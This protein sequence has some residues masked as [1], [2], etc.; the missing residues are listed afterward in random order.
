MKKNFKIYS[1][2][3]TILLVLF[4]AVV[5]LARPVIPGYE[6]NYDARF[7][8]TLSLIF[9]AFIGNLVCA[10]LA[11]K[12]ENL[13]KLFYN[14]PLLT[15]SRSALIIMTV[16]GS[17]LMLIPDC[18]AWIAAAV[19]IFI[20]AVNSFAVIK[21]RW[22]T[23][24][25]DQVDEKVKTQTAFIKKLTVEA[26]NVL[27][28]AKNEPVKAECQ[29]VYEAI[30]YS[31]PMSNDELIDIEN[32]IALKFDEFSIAVSNG[33]ENITDL[34]KGLVVLIADRNKKCKLLK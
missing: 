19:C 3:W 34:S 23:N 6:I 31:D 30:R 14:L 21:A 29:K 26:E 10:Y 25:V 5:F 18:P 28:C 1:L 12:A 4:A 20:L 32:Q 16:A 27:T 17:V 24:T 22:A 2:L 7:W 15:V 11:F 9:I 33:A 13:K 8:I